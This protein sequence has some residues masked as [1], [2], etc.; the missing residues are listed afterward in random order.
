VARPVIE[1]DLEDYVDR[2][3]QLE[4][5]LLLFAM[6]AHSDGVCG[7][8]GMHRAECAALFEELGW[9]SYEQYVSAM[10]PIVR[11]P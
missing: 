1:G 3:R 8:N 4:R 9:D 7:A 2:I 6:T 10:S 11:Q 5:A